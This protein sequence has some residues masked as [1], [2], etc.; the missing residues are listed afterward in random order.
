M[1]AR[2]DKNQQSQFKMNKSMKLKIRNNLENS[3]S[4]IFTQEVLTALEF[5]AKYNSDQ[6]AL[7]RK[8]IERRTKRIVNKEKISFLN[9]E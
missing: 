5:L 8:R 1:R 3:Y 7:M 2:L 6:K 9:P 4:D